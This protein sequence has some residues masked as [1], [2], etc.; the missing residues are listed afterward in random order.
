MVRREDVHVG[1]RFVWWPRDGVKMQIVVAISRPF[2][3][4][5]GSAVNVVN[6]ITGDRDAA[7]LADLEP[8]LIGVGAPGTLSAKDAADRLKDMEIALNRIV[9][10]RD[11]LLRP[12]Q[13][14]GGRGW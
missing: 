6:K 5:Q 1:D 9:E 13:V 14:R 11:E 10:Q 3:S 4:P 7:L 8:A 12:R 2:L